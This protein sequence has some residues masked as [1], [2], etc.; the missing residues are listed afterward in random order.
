MEDSS[1]SSTDKARLKGY[2]LKW[3][4]G[5]MLIGCA[6][7]VNALKSPS[8]LSKVLQGDKLDIVLKVS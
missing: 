5:N 6:M 1:V 8:I 4:Q 2:L 7:Y 3:Q